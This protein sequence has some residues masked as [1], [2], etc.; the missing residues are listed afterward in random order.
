[1]NI[2]EISKQR[3]RAKRLISSFLE[4]NN[5]IE[6]ETPIFSHT[7]IP[8]STI[9][10]YHTRRQ[11][12]RGDDKF[13]LLP[14]PELYMKRILS[15]TNASIYQFSKCFRNSEQSSNE[16]SPEFTMLEYYAVN[17]GEVFSQKITEE[18]FNILGNEFNIKEFKQ[19]FK[20]FSMREVVK[21]HAGID[22]NNVQD[23]KCLQDAL[24]RIGITVH[25][26]NESWADTFNRLFITLVEPNLDDKTT[27]LLIY[28]YPKQIECLCENAKDGMYKKRWELY[29][30]GIEL[31]NCYREE[32]DRKVIKEYFDKEDKLIKKE[33]VSF[34]SDFELINFSIPPSS[35]VALG[36]DRLL[37][38]L[39]KSTHI[40]DIIPYA[41]LIV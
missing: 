24:E 18:M 6:V 21:K 8:E 29:F 1:M 9:A 38:C 28:D 10:L 40:C 13:Y 27:P 2:I 34:M 37:M 15:E 7:A 19:K 23:T 36:F 31:A 17:E 22:L 3:T 35:G 25:D 16:H 5:Y 39:L 20:V 4:A 33:D 11:T 14:S 26:K 32:T 12:L 30:N 41:N